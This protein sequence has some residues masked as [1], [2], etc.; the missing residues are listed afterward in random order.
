MAPALADPDRLTQVVANLISNAAKFTRQGTDVDIRATKQ[1]DRIQ[2]SVRDRGDGIPENMRPKIF[3]KF[4]QADHSTSRERTGTGLGLSIAHHLVRL[5]NGD[6]SFVS[7][8]REGTTFFVRL[9]IAR[10]TETGLPAQ[11]WNRDHDD[12]APIPIARGAP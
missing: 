6:I 9:P 4:T 3:E 5:M 10:P 7:E 12:L 1:G 8:L 2:I 11:G